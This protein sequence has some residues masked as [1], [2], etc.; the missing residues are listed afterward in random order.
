MDVS[1]IIPSS[2]TDAKIEGTAASLRILTLIE[3][4]MDRKTYHICSISNTQY[5]LCCKAA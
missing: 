1:S 4:H 5:A 2:D 3:M